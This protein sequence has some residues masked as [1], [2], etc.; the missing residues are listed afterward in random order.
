[1]LFRSS[2]FVLAAI[3]HLVSADDSAAVA[4]EDSKVV[5]LTEDNFDEFVSSHPLVLAEFFAPWCGH[6]KNLGPQYVAAA[7][8][9]SDDE[10]PLVQVDCTQDRDL[11]AKFEI[12]GYPTMKVF[13][14]SSEDYSDYLGERKSESIISYMV[15]QSLPPVQSFSEIDAVDAAIDSAADPVILQ[16]AAEGVTL[17]NDTFYKIATELRDDATFVSTDNADY[18]AKYVKGD[19][20]AYVVFRPDDD[21]SDATVYS[22][23]VINEKNLKDFIDVESKPLFGD[24]DG[25]TFRGYMASGVPLAYFFYDDPAQKTGVKA[26]IQKLAK[27]FRGKINFVGLD[28]TK[29]GMHAQNLNME[30]KF[31]LFAIHDVDANLKYGISQATDLDPADIPDFVEQFADGSLEP[32]VKSEPIPETQNS[33]VY[34]LVGYEHDEVVNQP[35]DVFVKYYAPWCGH[36]KRLA[37][38]WQELADLYANDTDSKDKV[39][40]AEMDHTANDVN[41]LDIKG[42]PTLI[43]Y[44]A[45]G[46][47][48]VTY[49][50]A[51]T[52]EDLADF[53][54]EKGSTGVDGKPLYEAKKAEEET[55]KEKAAAA[56]EKVA[57][58][59]AAAAAKGK[60]AVDAVKG[61]AAAVKDKVVSAKDAAAAKVAGVKDAAGAKVA[62]AKGKVASAKGKVASAKDAAAAKVAGVKGKKDEAKDAAAAKVAAAKDAAS[63]K[64]ASVSAAASSINAKV[65]SKAAPAKSAYDSAKS[66]AD[67]AVSAAQESA[68]KAYTSIQAEYS[69]AKAV[70]ND[71]V[72]AAKSIASEKTAAAKSSLDAKVSSA[73]AVV[74]GA[75]AE[76]VAAKSAYLESVSSAQEKIAEAKEAVADKT[77]PAKEAAESA[78]ASAQ[79][80]AVAAQSSAAEKYNAAKESAKAAKESAKSQFSSVKASASSEYAAATSAAAEKYA[81]AKATAE[82]S[83]KGLQEKLDESRAKLNSDASSFQDVLQEKFGIA[84]NFLFEKFSSITSAIAPA[85]ATAT[86]A[87][88]E[89]TESKDEL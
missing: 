71:H 13:H 34:Y 81:S 27:K 56:E 10:I 48:A 18:V 80:A 6:C 82:E 61:E 30:Q 51:R 73:H 9:L 49:E 75:G 44:P 5:K 76:I 65:S 85:S 32:I 57:A 66:D 35:K 72:L 20:P 3:A 25:S 89:A 50:G 16:V 43:L 64:A 67:A 21:K 28:A 53:I 84:K 12:K 55:L 14:G 4:P 86:E 8:K 74:T 24:I 22:G 78:V 36:C 45:D 40:L 38:T 46:S 63:E 77:G 37:P 59:A 69:A 79:E 52:L 29:Y 19:K 41:G 39:L 1:M 60:A 15:K 58:A 87:A 54:K 23:E 11:C 83:V 88:P 47:D 31:P 33:T 62:A 7:D 26:T 42:Y 2:L 68:S 17:G 70:A